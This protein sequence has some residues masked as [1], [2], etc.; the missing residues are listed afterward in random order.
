MD[1]KRIWFWEMGRGVLIFYVL[2]GSYSFGGWMAFLGGRNGG[3]F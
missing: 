3:E 1:D 2:R